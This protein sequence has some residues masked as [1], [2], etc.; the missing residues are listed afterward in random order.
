MT[1]LLIDITELLPKQSKMYWKIGLIEWGT[2]RQAVAVIW[3]MCYILKW[4][5]SIFLMKPYF[6]KNIH[7]FFFIVDSNSNSRSTLY[8]TI[9][10]VGWLASGSINK[11]NSNFN[12]TF[13]LWLKSSSVIFISKLWKKVTIKYCTYKSHF[14][15]QLWHCEK[16]ENKKFT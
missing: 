1:I 13:R 5:G 7:K 16:N 6:W 3:M 4:K 14:W 12:Q 8:L 10:N 2:V 9:R 11:K 15:V